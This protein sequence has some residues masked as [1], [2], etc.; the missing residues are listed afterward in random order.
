MN[1][2]HVT[3]KQLSGRQAN[4]DEIINMLGLHYYNKTQS[5][6]LRAHNP[7]EKF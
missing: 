5:K 6:L 4:N 7:R 3:R 1:V 2:N